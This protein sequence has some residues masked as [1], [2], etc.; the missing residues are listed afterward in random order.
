MLCTS[1]NIIVTK[2]C[3]VLISSSFSSLLLVAMQDANTPVRSVL[4]SALAV[5]EIWQRIV[6]DQW[7]VGVDVENADDRYM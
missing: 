7:I 3:S 5:K 4:I 2:S 6:Y 1:I